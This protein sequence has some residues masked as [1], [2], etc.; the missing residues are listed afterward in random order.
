VGTNTSPGHYVF[1]DVAPGQYQVR[2]GPEVRPSGSGPY[3]I[4]WNGNAQTPTLA[5]TLTV[6]A[7]HIT[8]A[9]EV[10]QLGGTITGTLADSDGSPLPQPTHVRAYDLT[11]GA[12]FKVSTGTGGSYTIAHLLPGTYVVRYG[13]GIFVPP[14]WYGQAATRDASTPLTI[15]GA[16]TAT[17][18]AQLPT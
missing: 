4:E 10:M 2:F 15:V 5:P 8:E 14:V 16:T 13:D 3:A 17:A 7:G 18:N 1:F 9:D 12:A 11:T 6:T